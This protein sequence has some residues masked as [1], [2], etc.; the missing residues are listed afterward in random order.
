MLPPACLAPVT[1]D[2][3]SAV[4]ITAIPPITEPD[5]S[6]LVCPGDRVGHCSSCQRKTQR[7][8]SGGSPLCR[9][10][11]EPVRAKWGAAVRYVDT[12]P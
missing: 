3:D 8:G 9:W 10:C 4:T 11:L 1:P 6:A 12:R 2:Q 5:P 7:Y